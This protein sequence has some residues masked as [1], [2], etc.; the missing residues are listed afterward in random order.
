MNQK[1]TTISRTEEADQRAAQLLKDAVSC[2][3]ERAG[4]LGETPRRFFFPD[5]IQLI[6]IKVSVGSA[7]VSIRVSGSKDEKPQLQPPSP[8]ILP[9][10]CLD[11]APC[12]EAS[13]TG[14]SQ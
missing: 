11:E 3:A 14:P 4:V 12:R 13:Q 5:G 9:D 2:L 8:T 1:S 7:T 6:D 10:G